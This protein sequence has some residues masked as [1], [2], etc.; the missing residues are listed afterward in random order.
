MQT[1]R[2]SFIESLANVA[3]GFLITVVSL[4]ILFPFLGLE[5]NTGKNTLITGYLTVLSVLRNYL[6][7]RFF[8]R[9]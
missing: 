5:N 7:R 8:N 9:R 4:H 1:K 6:L 3:V 2:Q